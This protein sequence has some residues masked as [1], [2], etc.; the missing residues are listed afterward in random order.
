MLDPLSVNVH[1]VY[2]GHLSI[3]NSLVYVQ[4]HYFQITVYVQQLFYI[5]QFHPPLLYT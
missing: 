2:N 1:R 5:H 4:I 3:S